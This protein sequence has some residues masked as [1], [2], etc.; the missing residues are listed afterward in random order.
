M[1]LL[2]A[3]RLPVLLV[4]WI[5]LWLTKPIQTPWIK[6]TIGV[7]AGS[8]LGFLSMVALEVL[9]V[10]SVFSID[11][12]TGEREGFLFNLKKARAQG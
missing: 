8:I 3:L 6:V 7:I 11:E 12:I 9:I 2:T 4:S 5:C 10:V 1:V